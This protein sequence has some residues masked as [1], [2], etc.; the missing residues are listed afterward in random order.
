M[1]GTALRQALA[2]RR[3]PV[4][5]LIRR[6]PSAAGELQWDP[7][8]D[9]PIP[10]PG[11]LEGALAAIHL[12]G[13]NVGA[14]RWTESY[15]REM[16]AS[17]V[18]STRRLASVLAGLR[19]PPAT[20]LV[21][22]AIGIYG[23]RGDEL[24][25]ESSKPGNGFLADICRAWESAADPARQ[26]RIRVVNLRFG[27]VLGPE[28]AL[29]EMLT[30]FRLGLGARIGSGRQWMSWIS[31]DDTVAAVLFA[32]ERAETSGP[33]DIASPN[34]VT[35]ADFTRALGRQLARPALLSVPAFAMRIIF[36]Q[37][38]DEALLASARVQPRK[39]IAAGFQF[40]Q[41]NLDQALAAALPR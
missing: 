31:L 26:A 7:T 25:D 38:A 33:L 3:Y 36:G 14:H 21:A 19:K 27:V 1:L 13:A 28:G 17:R 16:I 23:D 9:T 41:P 10:D 11:A 37:M 34:P 12:S 6:K 20:L 2:S 8:S 40:S 4:L 22:S 15:K 29:K 5:Q 30:P 39:L 32:L 18:D 35:N 24:L